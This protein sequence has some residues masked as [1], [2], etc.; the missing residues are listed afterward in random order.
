[1]IDRFNFWRIDEVLLLLFLV[2]GCEESPVTD[3]SSGESNI[4]AGGATTVYDAG[5]NAFSTP[6]PNLSPESLEKHLA[7][8]AAFEQAFVTPPALVN[9][10]LGPTYN[11]LSC[12]AC[13]TRDG[14]GRPPSAGEPLVSMLFRISLPGASEHGGP[15]P[16]EGFGTQLQT[17]AVFG[18]VPEGD[19][20]V[21]WTEEPGEYADG[22]TY[23]LR[24]PL[25][26]VTGSLPGGALLSPR[27]APPVFGLGLL[28]AIPEETILSNADEDDLDSDGISGRPN[29]V[30]NVANGS[31]ELGRFGWK[32]NTP[33]LLQQSAGAYS[34]DMGVTSPYFPLEHCHGTPACD[35]LDNDPE[36]TDEVLRAV[37]FYVQTLGVPARR[38]VGDPVVGQGERLFLEIGCAGCHVEAFRTGIHS[39]VGE[40]SNQTIFPY[41]D[42]LLHDMGSDLADGRPDFLASGLE[43]RT[44]P[45]W[46]IGLTEVVSGHT[47]FLHD[48]RARNMQEA[49]L[50][51]GGEAEEV[52]DRFRGLSNENRNALFS[53]LM[54]L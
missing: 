14:R 42:L 21:N 32:A 54:S 25:H 31:S 33:T 19:V 28:E 8:D 49:I 34:E 37:E 10:G 22:T 4:A 45:L 44:P 9:E 1:M 51:H 48:G 52:R 15:V 39:H 29:F 7:G 18:V 43:W 41:T 23:S 16:V 3:T 40:V 38:R 26:V 6:A 24:R 53:F 12:I 35:T 27:V 17:R 13:H 11:N 50:W 2:S 5:S 46:G 30:W 20:V 36:V 47:L